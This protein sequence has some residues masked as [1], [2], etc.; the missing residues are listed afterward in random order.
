[1]SLLQS[2]FASLGLLLV[3]GIAGCGMVHSHVDC[4]QVAQQQRGGSSDE[5]VA[6]ATGVSIT[7]VQSCSQTESGGR[8]TAN[9]Y[10]DQPHLPVVPVI[11]AGALG[12]GAIGG[13]GGR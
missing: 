9:N 11:P 4:D 6:K 2:K 8:E 12:G 3:I 13:V 5:E 7:D 10:Q 1:M